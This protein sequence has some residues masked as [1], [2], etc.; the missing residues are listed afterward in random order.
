VA[1]R[2]S[3]LSKPKIFPLL[4]PALEQTAG[5]EHTL[6]FLL[7]IEIASLKPI[8]AALSSALYNKTR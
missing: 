4:F 7:R 8:L 1:N 2:A 5:E 6:L 3:N